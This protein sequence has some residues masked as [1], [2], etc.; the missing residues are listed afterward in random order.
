MRIR[1]QILSFF[2]WCKKFA[3]QP[4]ETINYKISKNNL[5]DTISNLQDEE[6]SS[7][8]EIEDMDSSCLTGIV[9]TS[10]HLSDSLL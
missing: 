6:N 5:A 4:F 7:Y 10:R 9:N 3:C 2:L 8:N 1:N